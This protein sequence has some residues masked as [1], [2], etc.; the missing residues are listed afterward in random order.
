MTFISTSRAK[1]VQTLAVDYPFP[2][3]L[4]ELRRN[5]HSLA[6]ILYTSTV[7]NRVAEIV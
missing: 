1:P 7:I 4:D 3:V 6:T 2:Y 5:G